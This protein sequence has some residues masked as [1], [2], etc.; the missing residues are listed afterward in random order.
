MSDVIKESPKTEEVD[1]KK[2]AGLNTLSG[3][4]TLM[5]IAIVALIIVVLLVITISNTRKT[6][7]DTYSRYTMNMAEAAATSVNALMDGAADDSPEGGA[8][9]EMS[10]VEQLKADPEGQREAMQESFGEALGSIVLDGIEGSYAYLVSADG[11]MVYHPTTEK[12][13]G[14]VENAAVKG[15]VSRLQA[16]ETPDKIGA[17]SVVYE[18]KGEDKYAGYAFTKGGN[19]VIVTGDYKLV[20]TPVDKLRNTA[21][22][23]GLVLAIVAAVIFLLLITMML[24]PLNQVTEIL[25]ATSR[26][27]FKKTEYGEKLTKR[28][29]EIGMIAKATSRMRKNLRGIVGQISDASE[30]IST[31]MSSLQG[32][33]D[34]VNIMCTDNS[35]TSQELAAAMEETAATTE[36]IKE[37]INSMQDDAKNINDLTMEGDRFAG[38]VQARAKELGETTVNASNR[39]RDI[40]ESVKVKADRA[41]EDSKSVDKINELTDTIMSISSQTSLLALNASIEAARAG[42]AGK[43]FAVVATEIG[44]L[45]KQTSDAVANINDIVG[46]V[47]SAVGNMSDCLTETTDFIGSNVLADYDEFAKVSEQYHSDAGEFRASMQKISDGISS[48][49]GEI[50]IVV[51]SVSNINATIGDAANGVSDIAGKTTDIVH[52]TSE[53]SDKVVECLDCIG[54]LDGIVARFNLE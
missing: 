27:D 47:I 22:V 36:N 18:F 38:E 31:D 40:Y 32:T 35:A 33:T 25:M 7:E 13:G 4:M 48:L 5:I 9:V 50:D 16:G 30:M 10:L 29:D 44:N 23:V 14:N 34:N 12:I 8:G 41:L 15:L 52:G 54:N 42:E 21:I 53:T 17:G 3:R 6:V 46:E 39:T 26:F 1:N 45:A 24:R 2:P 28:K 19:I 37:N 51:S 11:L 20:M 49:N 43:G